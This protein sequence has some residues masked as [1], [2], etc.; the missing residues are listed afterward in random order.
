MLP[1]R[2]TQQSIF[3]PAPLGFRQAFN[4]HQIKYSVDGF[5]PRLNVGWNVLTAAL[6]KFSNE[7]NA[8]ELNIFF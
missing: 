7:I 8:I 3:Q 6:N 2:R 4:P 1:I 5:N